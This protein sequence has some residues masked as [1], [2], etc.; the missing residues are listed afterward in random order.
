MR[1]SR[2]SL[3]SGTTWS[4]TPTTTVHTSAGDVVKKADPATYTRIRFVAGKVL[5]PNA[6]DTYTYEVRVK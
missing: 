1:S 5:E 4:A 3:D 6:I 2:Y